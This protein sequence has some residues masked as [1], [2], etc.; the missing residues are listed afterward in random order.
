VETPPGAQSQTDWGEYPRVDIGDGP[1]PL[2]AFVMVLS[3]SRKP[4]VV[5]SRREDQL[6][7]QSCHNEAYRRLQGIAAVNRIDN[8]KTAIASGAGA[9]GRIN[10]TYRSYARAVGF[11]IDACQSGEANAKGKVEAKV[12]LGRLRANPGVSRFDGLEH[13]QSWTDARLEQ[14]SNRALCPAT[15]Q[16]V[17]A[18]WEGELERLA[19]LPI[20]PE[21]YDVVVT[22]PVHK[23]CM[24]R[25]ENRS[26]PVP[27]AY[28][29]RM[30]EVRG[31]VATVQILADGQVVREYVRHSRERLLM[32]PTCYDGESTERVLAPPPLGRMGQKL[33]QIMEMPVEERPLD[34]YGALSEVAR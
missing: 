26:Y 1:E 17:H 33:Q 32:D 15:G 14:W 16:T 23:D 24:V 3:H 12:R 22:R 29:G 19:P 28:V 21:P 9:W 5:W 34:L 6:S 20:L 8:V 2:H 4:A 25:F 31:C 30:V 11:H 13:L 27:F 10:E 7:W 18:S